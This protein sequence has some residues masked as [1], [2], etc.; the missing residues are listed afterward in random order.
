MVALVVVIAF[1]WWQ[2]SQI[3]V[4]KL[5]TETVTRGT[6]AQLVS[7]SGFVEADNTVNLSFPTTGRISDIFVTEGE[8]VE[9]GTLLATIGQSHLA[10]ER[11]AA[12][13][14]LAK[15]EAARDELINGQTS[16]ERAVTDAT[17]AQAK[18]AWEQTVAT[19][20]EK[21]QNAQIALYSN[22]LI[23]YA[24]DPEEDA[25]PPTVT[26]SYQC[27]EEGSYVLDLYRSDTESGY[28]FT[29]EGLESGRATVSVDQPVL[30]GS[31]GLS[32][33]F[34][35]GDLYGNS[36]WT[37]QIPNTRSNTY[38]T[39]Q[40][41]LTLA[42]QQAAQNIQAA[43]DV[44]TLAESTASRET[45]APRIEALLSA[46][47]S[48]NAAQAELARTD[49]LLGDQSIYAPFAG[50]ITDVDKLPGEIATTDPF[51]TLLAEDA[52]TLTA[53]IP[54]IDITKILPN[55]K[56]TVVF[57]AKT[58][59]TLE[60]TIEYV[61]PLAIEIDG[62][63]YFE[64]KVV[65]TDTPSWLRSGLNADIDIILEEHTDVL[66]LP[67][68]FVTSENDKHFVILLE[69]DATQRTAVETGFVGNDGFIEVTSLSEGA[70]VV[71][72]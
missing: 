1:F 39:K 54:E 11:R 70:T 6:V 45:A 5:V 60:G 14:N 63:A 16:E 46:N 41:A 48:V 29:Y 13:A 56:T 50:M 61:S 52:F 17:V 28:S 64:A 7:V 38:L 71:A 22:D 65:L 19:E 55:Q 37:I 34:T 27:D 57:D 33:K 68:R 40:A 32:V 31:C 36:D 9:A 53:R 69:D 47:A 44:L 43:K 30:I 23:A 3:D 42:E 2:G 35:A 49:A 25:T 10:A 24:S 72:P 59:Q 62:V 67:K 58:S 21:I 12:L 66:R 18:A 26:G 4:S 15:A 20:L 8:L 51:I